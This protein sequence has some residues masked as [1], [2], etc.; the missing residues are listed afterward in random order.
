LK[1]GDEILTESADI[2]AHVL[3]YFTNIFAANSPLEINYLPDRLIPSLVT[4]EDNTLLTTLSLAE[5]IKTVVLNLCGDSAP[6]P[7][8]YLGHFYHSFWHI[9]GSDV[10]KSTQFFFT[11][12]FIMPNLNSNMLIL[13]PKVQGADRLDNFRPIVLANF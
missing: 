7:D 12:N 9:I 4:L 3:H 10:V 6:G 2:E 11:N 13:I 8:G 1:N 5:E